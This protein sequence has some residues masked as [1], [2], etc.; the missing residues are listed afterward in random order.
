MKYHQVKKSLIVDTFRP[1]FV[2][3]VYQNQKKLV[4]EANI[5]NKL[6][7]YNSRIGNIDMK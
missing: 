4:Q 5:K 6:S 3:N 7:K 2:E 1:S